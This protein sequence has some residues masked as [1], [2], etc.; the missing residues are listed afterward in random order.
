MFPYSQNSLENTLF[1]GQVV[2][3]LQKYFEMNKGKDLLAKVNIRKIRD[4]KMNQTELK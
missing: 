3:K 2:D 4:S 1:K